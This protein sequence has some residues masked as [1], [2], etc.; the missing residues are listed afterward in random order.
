MKY[1]RPESDML[2]LKRQ[3]PNTVQVIKTI[4]A[5]C[6]NRGGQLVIGVEDDQNIVG[7]SQTEMYRILESFDQAI[8]NACHPHI[9]PKM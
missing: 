3:L 8:F 9:I 2:E 5:F 1:P 6:N 7:L 4:V